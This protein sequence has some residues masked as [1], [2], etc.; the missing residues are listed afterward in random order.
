MIKT[1]N[2]QEKYCEIKVPLECTFTHDFYR[3][4]IFFRLFLFYGRLN[5]KIDQTLF[6]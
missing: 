4:D 5:H 6:E 1:K 3:I 2:E